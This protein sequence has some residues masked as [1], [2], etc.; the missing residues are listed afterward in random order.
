M[1]VDSGEVHDLLTGA[2]RGVGSDPSLILL[3]EDQPSTSPDGDY[4]R[5]FDWER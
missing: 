4:L 5:I 2:L 1:G 3:T